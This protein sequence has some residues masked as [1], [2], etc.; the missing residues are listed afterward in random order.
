[1]EAPE[2]IWLYQH[3]GQYWSDEWFA[4]PTLEPQAEYIRSDVVMDRIAEAINIR[5]PELVERDEEIDRL[6]A[7]IAEARQEQYHF[8]AECGEMSFDNQY[9]DREITRLEAELAELR[10][11]LKEY[12]WHRKDCMLFS[13]AEHPRCTCGFKQALKGE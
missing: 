13:I 4:Q 8:M 11:K 3:P 9:K 7:A 12:G 10:A 2:T 6:K 5:R 1:M